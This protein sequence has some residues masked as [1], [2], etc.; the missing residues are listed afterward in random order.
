MQTYF[1]LIKEAR[2]QSR[3]RKIRLDEAQGVYLATSRR[4]FGIEVLGLPSGRLL[5]L[6]DGQRTLAEIAAIIA[7][8]FHVSEEAIQAVIVGEV[9]HLQRQH[10]L[11][12]EV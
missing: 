7:A 12:M 1:E 9:R 6:A 8:Q 10:L 3:A 2:P 4:Q 11:Y 5:T